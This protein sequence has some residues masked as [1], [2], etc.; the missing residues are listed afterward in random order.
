LASALEA[1][2]KIAEARAA[3]EEAVRIFALNY[4]PGN[5]VLTEARAYSVRL[6]Q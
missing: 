4:D 3:A 2:D 5:P 1:Q 6:T